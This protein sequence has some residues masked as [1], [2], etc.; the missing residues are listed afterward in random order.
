[1]NVRKEITL[2]SNPG[3][4]SKGGKIWDQ[5]IEGKN[6]TPNE[7]IKRRTFR[8][9]TRTGKV[10]A[11]VLSSKERKEKGVKKKDKRGGGVNTYIHVRVKGKN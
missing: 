7:W 5:N 10:T 2:R 6:L 11:P 1:M 9:S 8:R 3:K 4:E